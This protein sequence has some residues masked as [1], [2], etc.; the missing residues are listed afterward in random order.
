MT[1]SYDGAHRDMEPGYLKNHFLIAMPTLADPHFFHSVVYLCEHSAEGAMGIVVNQPLVVTLGEVLQHTSIE[2]RTQD[3]KQH[4]VYLGGPVRRD[5]LF[6]IH[7]P[8]Q[9]W[10]STLAVTDSVGVTTSPDILSALA[11]DEFQGQAL[12]ALGYAGWGRGQLDGEMRRHGWYA[13]QG[14]PDILFDCPP[15]A[16][17]SMAWRAEG[18][19]PALLASETGRA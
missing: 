12:V 11:A 8:L 5:A 18:I 17:W 16:R 15:Q 9:R 1:K 3:V 19:D 14:R 6:V 2:V 13:A 4:P 7:Q 10:E